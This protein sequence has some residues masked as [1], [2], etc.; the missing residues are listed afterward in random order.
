LN[1][2]LAWPEFWD[3]S[4]ESVPMGVERSSVHQFLT[5]V[6]FFNIVAWTGAILG[7]SPNKGVLTVILSSIVSFMLLWDYGIGINKARINLFRGSK[8]SQIDDRDR[9]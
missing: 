5:L 7:P 9:I 2:G 4:F 3:I 1:G 6:I 8:A